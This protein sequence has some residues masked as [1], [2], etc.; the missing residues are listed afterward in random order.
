MLAYRLEQRNLLRAQHLSPEA[1]AAFYAEEENY[2]KFTLER[3]KTAYNPDFS[4]DEK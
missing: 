1:H 2:D 4:D 3:L